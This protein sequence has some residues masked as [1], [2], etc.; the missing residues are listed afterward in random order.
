VIRAVLRKELAVLW[1]SPLPYVVGALFNAVTGL[2][3]IDQLRGRGQALLQPL[4]PLAGFLLLVAVPVLAMRSLADERRTGS[5]DLLLAVSVPARSLVVGKWLAAWLVSMAV[6][7]PT[8]VFAAL[9]FRFGAPDS[10]PLTSGFL[11]LALLAG[12]VAALGVLASSLTSSQPV[13]AMVAVFAVLVL[14]FAG[15]GPDA[16]SAGLGGALAH[17]SLSERL[18]SFSG[19]AVDTGDVAFFVCLAA[20]GLVVAAAAVRPPRGLLRAAG[21]ALLLVAVVGA[22]V[23]ADRSRRVVDLTANDSLSLTAETKQVVGQVRQRTVVSVYLPADDPDRAAAGPLLLRY[24][25]LN[26]RI[27]VK[28]GAPADAPGDVR[29]LGLDPDL[30]GVA[31]SQGD[32]VEVAETVTEQDLTGAFVRLV[33]DRRR[34]VCAATGH[35]EAGFADEGPQGLSEAGRIMLANGYLLQPV[36]LLAT[37]A[38]PAACDALIV[39]NPISDLGP[40]RDGLARYLAADGRALFLTD[41]I[42]DVDLNPLLSP[43]GIT[44]H[45]GIVFEPDTRSAL[46]GDPTSPIVRRYTTAHPVARRVPPSYFPAPQ[47]LEVAEGREAEGLTTSRLADTSPSSYLETQP[48]TPSFD[49]A[50]D[51]RGPITVAA[52]ADKSRVEG[53]GAKRTRVVVFGDVDF[54]GNAVVGQ[55]GNSAFLLHAVDWLT[56]S[57]D[58]LVLSAHLPPYRPLSLTRGQLAY[59]RLLAVGIIPALFLLVGLLVWALR[60]GR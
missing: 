6:A 17:F 8:A 20:G 30:G 23:A 18:R 60:R 40:A 16:G 38:V 13:A 43:Y 47:G 33:R 36:D 1:A 37:P 49:P 24:Q 55:A 25:R 15:A 53:Q 31:V 11:G 35:G 34:N 41:P 52:A 59:A 51:R 48:L 28:T 26:R 12:A 57:D 21:V 14:W 42:S 3:F 9:V 54:A 46:P 56:A 58:E 29:R 4:F 5:L 19:G 39:A 2:L 32:K 7:A 45:R 50:E 22:D 27:D 10:G 44:V